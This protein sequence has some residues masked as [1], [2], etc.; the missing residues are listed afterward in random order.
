MLKGRRRRQSRGLLELLHQLPGIQ[1]VH[2]VDVPG[3]AIEHLNG[4]VP[5]VIDRNTGWLLVGLQPYF[6]SSCF[7]G[8]LPR[9]LIFIQNDLLVRPRS[10]IGKSDIQRNL[11]LLVQMIPNPVGKLLHGAGNGH[12]LWFPL[13]RGDGGSIADIGVEKMAHPGQGRI[14]KG[15]AGTGTALGIRTLQN[16]QLITAVRGEQSEGGGQLGPS[17]FKCPGSAAPAPWKGPVPGG[18]MVSVWLRWYMSPRPI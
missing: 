15:V 5:A 3:F 16:R 1:G 17:G 10:Q 12:P 13:E 6:S 9:L 18:R 8:S 11:I 14:L 7:I 4:Q 2:K